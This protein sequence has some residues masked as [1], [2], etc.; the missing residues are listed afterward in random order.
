[1]NS[2]F[3]SARDAEVIVV[4]GFYCRCCLVSKPASEQSADQRYCQSCYD[5]LISEA[6]ML[7]SSHRPWWVPKRAVEKTTR[8]SETGEQVGGE[9]SDAIP[10]TQ[11]T[12]GPCDIIPV[13]HKDGEVILS[14]EKAAPVARGRKRQELLEARILELA[15]K[16]LT[17]RAIARELGGQVSY[18]TVARFL[19]GQR[20][21]LPI[22]R[23]ESNG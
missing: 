23:G 9:T 17:T 14:Q 4:G 2:Y 22:A 10:A 7:P 12:R 5:V 3:S 18:R 20:L 1:M 8:V 11:V 13:G 19:A 15:A 16:G 6:A 21:L